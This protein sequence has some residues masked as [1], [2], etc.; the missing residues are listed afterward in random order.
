MA[1][2]KTTL[3][4]KLA[5]NLKLRERVIY[6]LAEDSKNLMLFGK[7]KNKKTWGEI[8][9]TDRKYC[10]WISKQ[11]PKDL[12]FLLFKQVIEKL[13]LCLPIKREKN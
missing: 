11:D 13:M 4:T 10:H 6:I 3:P 12:R 1:Q 8:Y 9:G 7:Y 5:Q 2:I